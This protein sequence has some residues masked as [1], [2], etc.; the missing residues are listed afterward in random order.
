M[1]QFGLDVLLYL[2]LLGAGLYY[3]CLD[4]S[5]PKAGKFIYQEF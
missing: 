5:P 3:T 4:H 2:V 1:K